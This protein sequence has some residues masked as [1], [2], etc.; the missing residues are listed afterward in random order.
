MALIRIDSSDFHG[1]SSYA[2]FSSVSLLSIFLFLRFVLNTVPDR[3]ADF[4]STESIVPAVLRLRLIARRILSAARAQ[5]HTGGFLS[6]GKI[7]PRESPG[8][9]TKIDQTKTEGFVEMPGNIAV[10][11][12]L[13]PAVPPLCVAPDAPVIYSSIPLKR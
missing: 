9:P 11:H 6:R 4:A 12:A 3:Y 7:H 8:P 10:V 13:R 2:L 5:R 1:A